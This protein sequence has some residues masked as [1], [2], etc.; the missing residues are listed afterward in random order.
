MQS[1]NESLS[2]KKR[3]IFIGESMLVF[4]FLRYAPNLLIK[5]FWIFFTI[6]WLVAILF[7]LINPNFYEDKR[8][9]LRLA[10]L[11]DIL[12]GALLFFEFFFNEKSIKAV[13]IV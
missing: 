4:L 10:L 5:N 1:G 12:F 6:F 8:V 3:L 11:L 9:G 13:S 7:F 2:F